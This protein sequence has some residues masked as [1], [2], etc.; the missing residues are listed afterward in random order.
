MDSVS[1]FGISTI[2]RMGTIRISTRAVSLFRRMAD[3]HFLH[4]F[5][6]RWISLWWVVSYVELAYNL[7]IKPC[8]F[9]NVLKSTKNH[10]L[11]WSRK[12]LHLLT[13]FKTKIF[14]L[15]FIQKLAT[16][17]WS[18]NQLLKVSLYRSTTFTYYT[19]ICNWRGVIDNLFRIVR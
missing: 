18:W 7:L 2:V 10:L 6:G 19:N 17:V 13:K 15:I 5:Y 11:C 1:E 8:H 12:L 16:Y 14:Q 3:K 9:S 4:I